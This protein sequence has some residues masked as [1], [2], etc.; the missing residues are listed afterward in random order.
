MTLYFNLGNFD[1]QDKELDINIKLQKFIWLQR[2]KLTLNVTKSNCMTLLN[3]EKYHIW[4][5][6]KQS[7]HLIFLKNFI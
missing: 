7:E 5:C 1:D 2:T 3:A 4:N 6:F